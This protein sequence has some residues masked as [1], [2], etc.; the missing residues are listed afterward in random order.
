MIKILLLFL[1]L[2]ILSPAGILQKAIDKAPSGA[3]L[4]LPSGIYRGNIVIDKPLTIIGSGKSVIIEGDLNATVI[5]L[6]SSQVTLRNLQITG[7]GDRMENLDAAISLNHVRECEISHCQ[8]SD[9]LYGIDMNM[10]KDSVISD[11]TITSKK[12]AVPLRG[13][14]LKLWYASGNI[15]RNNT[16]ERSR[17][18]T[19]TYSHHNL[20]SHNTF[21]HNR[22]GLHLSMSHGNRIEDNAFRYNAVGILMMGIKDT[23][24]TGNRILSSNGAA[25]IGV[26]ADKVSNFH[27]DH[28]TLKFNTKALYIDIKGTERGTQRFITHNT[29]SYNTEAFH[30]HADIRN[31]MIAHNVIKGNIEDVLQDLKAKYGK[32]NTVEYNYWDRYEGFDRNGDNIGDTPHRI[33]LYADQLWKYDNKIKFF[34]ATPIMSVINF[35]SRIA[36][37]ITPVLLLE[38]SKPLMSLPKEGA[39]Q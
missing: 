6:N 30:F 33:F 14:A 9:T 17:D 29:I 32:T 15:I 27:F 39:P 31:N 5:T 34:Y 10:V 20:F 36:P 35:L 8:I 13:D 1:T 3:T 24:V 18:V 12:H 25:G 11:N 38:D 19:L 4:K 21:L 23:N 22:Y 16:I 37:F 7:S 28:N 26:V 2:I